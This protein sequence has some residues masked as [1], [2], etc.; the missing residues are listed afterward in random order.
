VGREKLLGFTPVQYRPDFPMRF[1]SI[2]QARAHC[3]TC[4][5]WYN[6]EHRHSGIGYMTPDSVHQG[7]APAL[8]VARQATLDAAFQAHP[9][10]FKNRNPQPHSVPQ[11]RT[12]FFLDLDHE[13]RLVQL[14]PE[15]VVVARELGDMQ[16]VGAAGIDLGAALLRC[17]GA[18]RAGVA[19]CSRRRNTRPR[20]ASTRRSRR[21]AYRRRPPAECGACQRWRTS[22][23]VRATRPRRRRPPARL[24]PPVRAPLQSPYGLPPTRPDRE[25][26]SQLTSGPCADC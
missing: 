12:N 21:A 10:R 18:L 8:L 22:C 9:N 15:L 19:T 1:D 5:A 17:Q 2:E 11:Q 26:S 7:L 20:D 23:A 4:F 25:Y 24:L 6:T 3:Q 13:M 16:G 14:A